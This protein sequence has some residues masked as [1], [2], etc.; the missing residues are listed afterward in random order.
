MTALKWAVC[1][2]YTEV[3]KA[4]LDQNADVNMTDKVSI[5]L[6]YTLI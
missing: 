5:L 2:H 6:L 1:R 3:V 4:L